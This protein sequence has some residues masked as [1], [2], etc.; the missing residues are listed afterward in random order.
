MT[1]RIAPRRRPTLFSDPIFAAIDEHRAAIALRESLYTV[2]YLITRT[3]AALMRLLATVAESKDRLDFAWV[4]QV[5]DRPR[6]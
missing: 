3:I 6:R 4:A 5:S 2:L 1:K